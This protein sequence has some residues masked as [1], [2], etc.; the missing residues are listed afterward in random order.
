MTMVL[1]EVCRINEAKD[2][3]LCHVCFALEEHKTA[4]DLDGSQSEASSEVPEAVITDVTYIKSELLCYAIRYAQS[5]S[6]DKL[7][8]VICSS[9]TVNEIKE[10]KDNLWKVFG[11]H[12]DPNP[13]RSGRRSTPVAETE[14]DDIVKLGILPLANKKL[15]ERSSVKF[16]VVDLDKVPKYNPEET[17]VHSMMAS[18]AELQGKFQAMDNCIRRNASH[19]EELRTNT[20]RMH[21]MMRKCAPVQPAKFSNELQNHFPP[22]AK[23]SASWR[24]AMLQ[25]TSA[26]TSI[27]STPYVAQHPELLSNTSPR[28]F[29]QS[30]SQPLNS[31]N[32]N[33]QQQ[34]FRN[35]DQIDARQRKKQ[36]LM[37]K[38]KSVNIII[39]NRNGSKLTGAETSKTIFV[40]NVDKNWTEGDISNEM[41]CHDVTPVFV[42]CVSHVES[43]TKSFKV[44]IKQADQD[45]VMCAEFWP[46]RVKCREWI[47]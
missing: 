28:R 34:D 12:L 26:S 41:K 29:Q 15:F 20:D 43:Y 30:E 31:N 25:E 13:R 36:T 23:Q 10:A 14:A 2:N 21:H 4:S 19:I 32:E 42:K 17:N 7:V 35:R 1:C 38:T 45:K 33:A 9:F 3:D 27:K 5:S 6:P 39:G 16:C 8:A 11:A 37:A 44:V 46:E 22:L 24:D 18:I 47:Q 40:S